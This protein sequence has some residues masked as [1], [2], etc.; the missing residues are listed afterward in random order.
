[1]QTPP[2]ATGPAAGNLHSFRKT[3]QNPLKKNPPPFPET[4]RQTGTGSRRQQARYSE[5]TPFIFIHLHRLLCKRECRFFPINPVTEHP[6]G[7]RA[8]P[9]GSPAHTDLWNRSASE[10][11]FARKPKV[12]RPQE[13]RSKLHPP[14]Q[15]SGSR[16][17]NTARSFS[18][19]ITCAGVP[20]AKTA[21]SFISR[22][23]S[24]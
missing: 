24:R 20:P 21:P 22:A 15:D 13:T 12:E 7:R 16:Y 5:K 8:D 17:R 2:P 9:G 23:S 11:A 1:M 19:R 3:P 10:T 14:Y 6:S 18:G 4:V